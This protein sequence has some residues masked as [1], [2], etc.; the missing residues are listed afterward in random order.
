MVD[1]IEGLS[2]QHFINLGGDYLGTAEALE[3]KKHFGPAAFFYDAARTNLGKGRAN[4]GSVGY[5][6]RHSESCAALARQ[7]GEDIDIFLEF[8]LEKFHRNL[9]ECLYNYYVG[10]ADSIAGRMSQMYRAQDAEGIFQLAT[11][12]LPLSVVFPEPVSWGVDEFDS[13]YRGCAY[14]MQGKYTEAIEPLKHAYDLSHFPPVALRPLAHVYTDL[15]CGFRAFQYGKALVRANNRPAAVPFLEEAVEKLRDQDEMPEAVQAAGCAMVYLCYC[16]PLSDASFYLHNALAIFQEAEGAQ[17]MEEVAAYIETRNL[18]GRGEEWAKDIDNDIRNAVKSGYVPPV[19]L[20]AVANAWERLGRHEN[21]VRFA[22]HVLE[23][24]E[25]VDSEVES[26]LRKRLSRAEFYLG[27]LEKIEE[28]KQYALKGDLSTATSLI[29]SACAIAKLLDDLPLLESLQADRQEYY[30]RNPEKIDEHRAYMFDLL[31]QGDFTAASKFFGQVKSA[32]P[33][34]AAVDELGEDVLR[35][36]RKYIERHLATAQQHIRER[37]VEDAENSIAQAC[38]TDADSLFPTLLQETR[39]RLADLKA[40]LKHEEAV[41]KVKEK[42]FQ[43]ATAL[44]IHAKEVKDLSPEMGA[45]LAKRLDELREEEEKAV[46]RRRA[47]LANLITTDNYEDAQTLLQDA[48]AQ[49]HTEEFAEQYEEVGKHFKARAQIA[50]AEELAKDKQFDRAINVL[51]EILADEHKAVR[52]LHERATELQKR[53]L[54]DKEEN[55]KH[56]AATSLQAAVQQCSGKRYDLAL[57]TVR[58]ILESDCGPK[59]RQQALALKEQMAPALKRIR[60]N[61]CICTDQRVRLG[62]H[63]AGI[64]LFLL[65]WVG[66][67]VTFVPALALS[68]LAS[69]AIVFCGE[70]YLRKSNLLHDGHYHLLSYGAAAGL[71]FVLVLGIQLVAGSSWLGLTVGGVVGFGCFFL[72]DK[73]LAKQCPAL[74]LPRWWASDPQ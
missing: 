62:G 36:K 59:H 25:R 37:N 38:K 70:C 28:A 52:L 12:T 40:F 61:T 53:I 49:Q 51:E 11:M 35:F 14:L 50:K 45:K 65:F 19:V 41:A 31:E 17:G 8:G 71:C 5:A 27:V 3:Q 64:V 32:Q 9:D 68:L 33:T 54:S 72:V 42:D 73:A 43:Q 4:I 39:Q 66:T 21:V 24:G 57:R 46:S 55:L 2:Q 44:L 1:F 69:A 10:Q 13:Y 60:D 48:L 34:N 15:V 63:G 18:E 16:K 6:G 30:I 47:K 56:E 23:F 22:S 7:R 26:C 58:E 20:D 29:D 74:F 67:S